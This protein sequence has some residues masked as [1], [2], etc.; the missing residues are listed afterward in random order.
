MAGRKE[1]KGKKNT[2]PQCTKKSH[3]GPKVWN[4][5]KESDNEVEEEMR[6]EI[7]DDTLK[8]LSLRSQRKGKP[9]DRDINNSPNQETMIIREHSA[10]KLFNLRKTFN[11]Q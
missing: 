2:G 4:L 5:W 11:K 3:L 8:I 7:V 6:V 1:A 10:S 9:I